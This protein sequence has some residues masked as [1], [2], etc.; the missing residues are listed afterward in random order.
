MMVD[1]WAREFPGAVIVSDLEGIVLDMND[2]AAR[3]FE[4]DGGRALIGRNLLDCHPEPARTK[5]V[6]LLKSRQKNVYTIEKRGVRKLIYQSPWYENG[7]CRGFVELSLE[8][9]SEMPHFI[10]G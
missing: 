9:P 6:D 7:E 3:D 4:T 10:R 5:T 2:R 1:L 8:I